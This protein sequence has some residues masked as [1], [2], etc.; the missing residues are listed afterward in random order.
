MF[1]N[2]INISLSGREETVLFTCEVNG[3]ADILPFALSLRKATEI[4]GSLGGIRRNVVMLWPEAD[5]WKVGPCEHFKVS[6]ELDQKDR[7]SSFMSGRV[8]QSG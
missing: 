2:M 7:A 6:V 8:N 4:V 1:K 5:G 3:T